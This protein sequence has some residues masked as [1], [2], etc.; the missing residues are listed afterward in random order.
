[1]TTLYIATCLIVSWALNPSPTTLFILDVK[2]SGQRSARKT[3][4][5][6]ANAIISPS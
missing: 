5:V 2:S 4:H 6:L 1:M 3:I